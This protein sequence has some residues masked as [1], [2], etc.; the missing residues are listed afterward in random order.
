ML[1]RGVEA[2]SGIEQLGS[3]VQPCWSLIKTS[4]EEATAVGICPRLTLRWVIRGP[5][6]PVN[7]NLVAATRRCNRPT[8]NNQQDFQFAEVSPGS[9]TKWL[10][11]SS[12]NAILLSEVSHINQGDQSALAAGE[13][14]RMPPPAMASF[15]KGLWSDT[16]HL[17]Y[18][19]LLG[20]LR[21]A[22]HYLKKGVYIKT[23]VVISL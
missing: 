3:K 4:F 10:H 21:P 12:E 16:K 19:G 5:S 8:V 1:T 23:A 11:S 9:R 6:P 17:Y 13:D 14:H 18:T 2:S 22:S 7:A 15:I 20:A